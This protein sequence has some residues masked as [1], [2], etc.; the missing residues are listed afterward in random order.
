MGH[1]MSCPYELGA[2][3][4][5][6]DTLR[7]SAPARETRTKGRPF[8]R[9]DKRDAGATA[10]GFWRRRRREAEEGPEGADVAAVVAWAVDG[11]FEE[12]GAVGAAEARMIQ[13]AREGL[14]A[15]VAAADVLVAVEAGGEGGFRIVDVDYADVFEADRGVG[16][17]EGAVEAFGGADFEAGG[18]EMG[19]VEADARLGDNAAGARGLQDLTQMI[20]LRAQASSLPCGVF[21]QDADGTAGRADT[22]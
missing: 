18:Q 22:A 13:D 8:L 4:A 12:E 9:Q 11:G 10:G 21:D 14:L 6:A 1:D 20:E 2:T 19:C 7:W 5:R 17:I 15:D 16:F 3:T